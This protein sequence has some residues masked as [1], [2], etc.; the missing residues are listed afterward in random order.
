MKEA[1]KLYRAAMRKFRIAL[2]IAV[3]TPIDNIRDSDDRDIYLA[4]FEEA[5]DAWADLWG[6]NRFGIDESRYIHCELCRDAVHQAIT[7][8]TKH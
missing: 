6:N 3:H 8:K 5:T 2:M 4:F 7:R 1:R